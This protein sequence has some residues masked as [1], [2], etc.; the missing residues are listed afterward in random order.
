MELGVERV[1]VPVT[2]MTLKCH[3]CRRDI[4]KKIET[5]HVVMFYH[6]E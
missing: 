4:V 3:T 1:P 2:P 5:C 6:A